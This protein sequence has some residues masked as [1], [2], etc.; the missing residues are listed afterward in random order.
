M[1]ARLT[2][3]GRGAVAVVVFSGDADG[4]DR[5]APQLFRAANGKPL[6]EQTTDQIVFGH[7]GREETPG[8]DVVLCRRGPAS[9]E[10]HCHG[11]DVAVRRILSDLQTCGFETVD[12]SSLA[13]VH[14]GV[15]GQEL[16]WA[17]SEAPTARTAAILLD[18]WQGTWRD[19]IEGIR[20][21][22]A[23]KY[24][25]G[26]VG[27]RSQSLAGPTLRDASE[28]E[29]VE[30]LRAK[31]QGMLGWSRFAL[32]LTVPWSVVL[33]GRPNVGKSSLLN[34][35]LG[36][37]RAIVFDEPGTTRDVV[38]GDTAIEGWPVRLSDTAGIRETADGLEAEGIALARAQFE[39]AD[40]RLLIV[41]VNQPPTSADL[42]AMQ[43]W[44]DAIVVAH[45]S[46]LPDRWGD[47]LPRDV[48]RVSSLL[49]TGVEKLLSL[50]ARKLVPETPSAGTPLPLTSRQIRLLEAAAG[51]LASGIGPRC[52]QLLDELVS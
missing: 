13:Q 21:E 33:G 45:K 48:V 37:S 49:S 24:V 47:A 43:A 11:G 41:D 28:P 15:S 50:I 27:L 5:A 1:A 42:A 30:R 4:L 8:E 6:V 38:T 14:G 29:L 16:Q 12:S 22:L 26:A 31:L 2:P 17:V 52:Q 39:T 36:Y 32:H 7:W 40:C 18:Q 51:A 10:V 34:R 35:L 3:A 9:F 25:Q 23:Q 44:P 46:D 19:G 20:G